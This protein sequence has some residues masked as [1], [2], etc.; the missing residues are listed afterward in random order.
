[1]R[2][3]R[4]VVP[5]FLI[6]DYQNV[7]YANTMMRPP[8]EMYGQAPIENSDGADINYQHAFGDLNFTAQAFAGVSRGK[9]FVSRQRLDRHL[10]RTAAGSAWPANT[11]VP[12]ARGPRPRRHEINDIQPINALTSTLTS[13]LR[14]LASDLTFNR[15][16]NRLHLDR[17]HHGLE[18]RRRP[19][20]IRPAPR[21]GPVYLPDTNAWYAM[22]G[23]RFGKVLPYYAHASAKGAG[24][25]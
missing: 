11:A 23:Y 5:T 21:Q 22:V 24:T 1:V 17:R 12:A 20:R 6:S 2:V 19:G 8:I 14:Q 7:G 13:R 9:L 16:E 3:G 10:P 25:A 15:Q 18:Q 4:V